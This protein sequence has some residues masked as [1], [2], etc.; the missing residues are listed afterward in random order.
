M[1]AF[2]EVLSSTITSLTAQCWQDDDVTQAPNMVPRF[3]SF[4]MADSVELG[5]LVYAVVFDVI[6]GPQDNIHKPAALRLSREEL[7]AEQPQI[8]ALL[9]TE[10]HAAI[11]GYSERGRF[12]P[13]LP[14]HPPQVHDFVYPTSKEE[15][16]KVTEDLDFVRLISGVTSVPT[17]ELI[18]AT[19]K[20]AGKAY[21]DEY[22][23]LVRAGQ[24]L[25]QNLE[26]DYNRL[27]SVLRKIKPRA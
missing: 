15:V 14:P 13:G 23:F 7:R 24:S 1:A 20:E 10:V 8:F 27:A 26:G 25:A 16:R 5:I 12:E 17:D 21:P 9:K 11:V 22:E 19:I 2:G 4:I 3:G 18:A 6:A